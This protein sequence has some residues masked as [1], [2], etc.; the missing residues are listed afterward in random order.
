MAK[1]NPQ[2]AA[3]HIAAASAVRNTWASRGEMLKKNGFSPF[4]KEKD[5][6]GTSIRVG[7]SK[8]G[9]TFS[10]RAIYSG[11]KPD[12]K[13]GTERS[14]VRSLL[15]VRQTAITTRNTSENGITSKSREVTHTNSLTDQT[16]W[17]KSKQES[18]HA[19]KDGTVARVAVETKSGWGLNAG[20]YANSTARVQVEERRPGGGRNIQRAS[21]KASGSWTD[22]YSKVTELK[23]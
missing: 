3:G 11:T 17:V 10:S 23:E 14:Q 16:F 4:A 2:T 13:I 18:T 19:H 12:Q 6:N 9:V 7:F 21:A 1:V 20:V 5:A 15:G 22:S 8:A